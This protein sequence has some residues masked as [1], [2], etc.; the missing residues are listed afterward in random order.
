MSTNYSRTYMKFGTI[1]ITIE[2]DSEFVSNQFREIFHL[3]PNQSPSEDVQ[4]DFVQRDR[5]DNTDQ[6]KLSR[7]S[8]EKKEKQDQKKKAKTTKSS[9]KA[10]KT[11]QSDT[12]AGPNKVLNVLGSD[13]GQWL[14]YLPNTAE[15]RDKILIAAYFKQKTN[16]DH[17]FYIRGIRALLKEYEISVSSLSN[18]LDTFE[19]QKIISKVA[20]TSRRG[21]QF[22]KEG[23]KYIEDL[24]ASQIN[25]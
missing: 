8:S 17:K 19:I 3:Q 23:E 10:T 7:P 25:T 9:E 20:E 2:G 1:E 22:S 24:L 12:P 16:S 21:Y 4:E 18:F 14:A 5:T 15:L 6:Q 11:S 13:F